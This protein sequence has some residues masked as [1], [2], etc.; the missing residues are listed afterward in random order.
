M[1]EFSNLS[2]KYDN[3]DF[4]TPRG[5]TKAKNVKIAILLEFVNFTGIIQTFS[6]T[7]YREIVDN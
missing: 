6:P 4:Q 5:G 7:A 3:F 1:R 2:L